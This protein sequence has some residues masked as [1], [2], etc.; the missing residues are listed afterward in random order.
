MFFKRIDADQRQNPLGVKHLFELGLGVFAGPPRALSGGFGHHLLEDGAACDVD[1]VVSLHDA[2]ASQTR[3]SMGGAA[4][5]PMSWSAVKV[6]L[7]TSEAKELLSLVGDLYRLSKDNQAFLEAR[8][9]V[10]AD[11]LRHYRV[12]VEESLYPDVIKNKPIQIARAKKAISDYKAAV[13]DPRGEAELMLCFVE[14]GTDYTADVGD[15]N[16]SF[17]EALILMYGRA[18]DQVLRLPEGAREPFQDRLEELLDSSSR[19]GWGYPDALREH[20]ERGF[21]D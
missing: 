14:K 15:I 9:A 1:A 8:C 20:Y 17:Y 2:S 5:L 16:A 11:P 10:A 19:L 18:V 12:I 4:L 21:G 13:G 7:S 6:K 3:E